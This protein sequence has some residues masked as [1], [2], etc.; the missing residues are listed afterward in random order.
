MGWDG[1]GLPAEN[2]AIKNKV[3]PNIAV[4]QN[5][6]RFKEQL[7]IIGFDYDWSREINTTDPKFYKWTQWVFLQLY[8]KG[9][10]YES[11][12]PVNWCPTDKT[13]LANEDVEPDGTCE[14]CGTK[15][16]KRPMRQWVLKITDYADRLLSD[17]DKLPKWPDGVKEAQRN[18]IGRKEGITISHKVE[19]KNIVRKEM[20]KIKEFFLPFKLQIFDAFIKKIKNKHVVHGLVYLEKGAWPDKNLLEKLKQLPPQFSIRIDPG[21]LL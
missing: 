17:L 15:V 8:K 2:F 14:R 19:G 20:E 3:H 16:E 1:F 7:S 10:A 9:L 5:I 13:V 11:N 12:E 18:W 6:A 4:N 21:S